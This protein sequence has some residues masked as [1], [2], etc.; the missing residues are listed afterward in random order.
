M[1][2][3]SCVSHTRTQRSP[4]DCV[5]RWGEA[6]C[7]ALDAD[8][9]T[10]AGRGDLAIAQAALDAGANPD[11]PDGQGITPLM[12][13]IVWGH[14]DVAMLLI[15]R[16]SRFDTTNEFGTSPV[17]LA[18]RHEQFE[19]AERIV[20]SGGQ[21]GALNDEEAS[22]LIAAA[23]A[24]QSRIM[25]LILERAGREAIQPEV[26]KVACT[27][28]R[29]Y[30]HE[31]LSAGPPCS[32]IDI[33]PDDVRLLAQGLPFVP[34]DLQETFVALDATLQEDVRRRMLRDDFAWDSQHFGLG[35]G[36]RNEWGL[37]TGSRLAKYFHGLGIHHPDDMS[38][39]I[40]ESYRRRLH[41][42]PLDLEGQL[43][44]YRDYWKKYGCLEPDAFI[45]AIDGND[46]PRINALLSSGEA[47]VESAY[48]DEYLRPLMWA[49]RSGAIDSMIALLA[50]GADVNA[51]DRG[52]KT[53]AMWAAEEGHLRALDVLLEAG[54]DAFHATNW[55]DTALV[56]AARGGHVDVVELLLRR[57]S[58]PPS[59]GDLGEA[60]VGAAREGHQ[61]VLTIL[62]NAGASVEWKNRI[63]RTPLTE[64]LRSGHVQAVRI[65]IES[66]A[67]LEAA[68]VDGCDPLEC[69]YGAEV[70]K[71]LRS[72]ASRRR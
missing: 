29:N 52:N 21:L 50:A 25:E 57:R 1:L 2:V 28:A 27:G 65:L 71:Y 48:C 67:D 15:S 37:W 19:V 24:G 13:A 14:P 3:S 39:I 6:E 22:P 69:A 11:V 26:M 43:Q 33:P 49:A 72:V 51:T 9:L 70:R 32:S 56:Y 36:L 38:G 18:L 68:S 35:L 63:G 31:S 10:A 47:E 5:R 17:V 42:Q 44:E 41:G 4:H 8:V 53:A 66:G 20:E 7:R 16:G 12:N 34:R 60:L 40:L 64:A 45:A 61:D 30:G 55:D 46:V 54:A 62:M 58:S 23:K 59:E